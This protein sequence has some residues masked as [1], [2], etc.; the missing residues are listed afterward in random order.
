MQVKETLSEGLKREYAVILPK[1]ELDS[2]ANE[3]LASIKGQVN[4]AG[5]RPGKVPLPH[6][7]RV[8]GKSVMSEVIE[9]A[10]SDANNKIMA[11]GGFRLA[12]EPKVELAS[13]DEKSIKA[14]IEGKADLAYTVA[15]EI[16]PKIELADFS[17]IKIE[18]PV[19]AITD[20]D[21]D[22]A[23]RKIAE[24][25][26][27]FSPKEGKAQLGDRV[28]ISFVGTIDGE[29]FEGGTGDEVPVVIGAGRMIP[30]FEDQ[31]IGLVAGEGGTVNVRFPDDYAVAAVAG[32]DAKFEVKVGQVQSPDEIKVDEDFAT[33]LGMESL[34]K[35]KNNVRERLAY[36]N[37]FAS[38]Q[39]AKRKLLDQLD[40][41][42]KFEIPP[43]LVDQEFEGIW[44]Q[45][46][47]DL[48]TRRTTF[49]QEGTSEEKARIE[50]R[51][52]ADRRVRLGLVLAEIGE[53]NAIKVSEEEL[54]R[55]V[56]DQA[57]QYRGQ[58]QQI[59]DYYRKNPLA[60]AQLR[61]PIFEDKIIDFLLE[62]V[63]VT[64]L[65]VTKEELL[66]E[67]EDDD[68]T[69][70]ATKSEKSAKAAKPKTAK[71]KK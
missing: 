28:T 36:E 8:Y 2:K 18:K 9:Q 48:E 40:Q 59:V 13:K 52:I 39:K 35:L 47:K 42:H 31:L 62:L 7:K 65:P 55:A 54:N 1:A 4:L 29:K 26:R 24:G 58:E 63:E 20:S 69:A 51:K 10:I 71:K 56:I 12:M 46:Q 19:A 34:E 15:M 64:E 25:M 11:D 23:V 16:L 38:R 37:F 3:K 22:D 61:S 43:T 14:V 21:V 5:F 32:K 50:Y 68:E 67:D 66:K 30:G 27:S 49:E 41:L 53:K 57:R 45:I 33:K 44:Q 6:L 17:K 70:K 60:L